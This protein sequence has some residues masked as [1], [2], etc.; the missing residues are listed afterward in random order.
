VSTNGYLAR[1]AACAAA[2]RPALRAGAWRSVLLTDARP[3]SIGLGCCRL[4]LRVSYF[5]PIPLSCLL[6]PGI[7]ACCPCG[8]DSSYAIPAAAVTAS[9]ARRACTAARGGAPVHDLLALPDGAQRGG[10]VHA[11]LHVLADVHIGGDAVV[12]HEVEQREQVAADQ[13]QREREYEAVA[14]DLRPRACGNQEG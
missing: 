5:D 8:T 12:V 13:A 1:G 14:G 6:W 3:S 7:S 9:A 4:L 10:A 11:R 2:G